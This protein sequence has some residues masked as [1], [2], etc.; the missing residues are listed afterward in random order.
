MNPH[1]DDLNDI[2][3]YFQ[4]YVMDVKIY[5]MHI[6]VTTALT[7]FYA[8]DSAINNTVFS[9]NNTAKRSMKNWFPRS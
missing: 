9:T 1:M 6:I 8:S 5:S 7:Y 2:K 3:M 4:F